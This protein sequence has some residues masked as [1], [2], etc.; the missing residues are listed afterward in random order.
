MLFLI[1]GNFGSFVLLTFF[2][3]LT[4]SRAVSLLE[5]GFPGVLDVFAALLTLIFYYLTYA[6]TIALTES[7]EKSL[8]ASCLS[9]A[10]S[11]PFGFSRCLSS[12]CCSL[13]PPEFNSERPGCLPCLQCEGLLVELFGF[14]GRTLPLL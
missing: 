5:V 2:N 14:L 8:P 3:I 11:L 13:L 10:R 9:S 1:P 4:V 12:L 6:S 7:S